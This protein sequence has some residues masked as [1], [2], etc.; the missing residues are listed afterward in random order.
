M[1]TTN[2]LLKKTGLTL[3]QIDHWARQGYLRTEEGYSGGT[4][5]PRVYR[6]GELRI[7]L[8]M[9]DLVACGVRPEHAHRLARGDQALMT[10]LELTLSAIRAVTDSPSAT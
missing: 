4:G 8:R 6:D 2:V 9:R 5:K 7:A 1:I 3:R 10:K